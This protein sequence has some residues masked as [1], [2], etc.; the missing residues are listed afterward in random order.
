VI[1]PDYLA[2]GLRLVICGTAA[3]RA[4]AARGHYYA[5]PGNLLWEYLYL[6]GLTPVRLRPEDDGAVLSSGIGLTDVAKRVAGADSQIPRDAYDVGGFIAKMEKFRP[7][8][9]AFHGKESARAV[10]KYLGHRGDVTYGEQSLSIGGSRIFVLPS[11]SG[12][13][14]RRD[15]DG[16]GDRLEWF[17]ELSALAGFGDRDP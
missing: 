12:A 6:A 3:G 16:K 1:L 4:S 14:R 15:Y 5:G 10:L 7:K 2:P 13:N 9:V 17:R 8:W 11:A